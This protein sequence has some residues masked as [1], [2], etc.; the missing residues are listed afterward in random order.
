MS[1]KIKTLKKQY[2]SIC[3]KYI[4]TFCEKQD[5]IFEGWVADIVGGVACCNDFFFS[6]DDIVLDVN[7]EQKPGDIIDWYYGNLEID[8]VHINY[9]SY[10]KGLRISDL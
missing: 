2:E 9:Y 3:N 10:I 5:F 7:T 6:F 1:N 8:G 4:L